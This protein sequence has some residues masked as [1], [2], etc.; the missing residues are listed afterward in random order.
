MLSGSIWG[1]SFFLLCFLCVCPVDV[2]EHVRVSGSC[3]QERAGNQR[4]AVQLQPSAKKCAAVLLRGIFVLLL[5]GKEKLELRRK[6]FLRVQLVAEVQSPDSA[7]CV[8]LDTLGLDVVRSVRTPSEITQVEL[9]LVP[10]LVETHGHGAD[11]GF[12]ARRA[13]IVRCTESS[14]DTLVIQHGDLERE[15]LLQV[16]NDHHEERQLDA[17]RLALLS[18]ARNEA[19][20]DIAAD[21]LEDARLNVLVGQA[22][23]VAV[24]HLLV[25]DLQW[26]RSNG[27]QDGEES[28]LEGVLEH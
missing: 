28:T 25:P 8:H 14:A 17:E 5:D 2:I 16:L 13:L 27:V 7:V 4:K 10:A 18:W 6:V 9:N 23:D 22:L 19:G 3:L 11:E 12:H 26:T 15:V 1:F 24:A 20:V 21:E